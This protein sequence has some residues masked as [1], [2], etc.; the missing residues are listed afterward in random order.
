MTLVHIK[1]IECSIKH[2]F[3][4]MVVIYSKHHFSYGCFQNE[5]SIYL[6]DHNAA[7][8]LPH[9]TTVYTG[10]LYEVWKAMEYSNTRKINYASSS[11]TPFNAL[12]EMYPTHPILIS[13]I[14][15]LWKVYENGITL[16]LMWVPHT[17][18]R[19]NE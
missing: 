7:F 16:K 14:Q 12:A 13:I 4:M 5:I 2:I 18:I 11:S 9:I 15:E 17:G 6:K 10:E 3:A 19:G 8:K 1:S